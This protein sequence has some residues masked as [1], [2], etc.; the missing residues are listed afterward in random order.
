MEIHVE[1]SDHHSAPV[2]VK[3]CR[4]EDIATWCIAVAGGTDRVFKRGMDNVT[5]I[6]GES[7]LVI[8]SSLLAYMSSI[9]DY[10]L[11][12][13]PNENCFYFVLI[14]V[15]YFIEINVKREL[16]CTCVPLALKV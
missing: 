12:N 2:F 1:C 16:Y 4:L 3:A 15:L 5:G 9:Y 7:N 10:K 6:H 8:K 11:L 13:G 14:T